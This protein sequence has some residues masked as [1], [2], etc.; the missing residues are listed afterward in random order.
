MLAGQSGDSAEEPAASI[1]LGEI[2]NG[3]AAVRSTAG[4]RK[5]LVIR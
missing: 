2:D 5:K 3:M 4:H 1:V